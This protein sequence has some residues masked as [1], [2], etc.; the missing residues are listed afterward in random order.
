MAGGARASRRAHRPA[1]RALADSRDLLH[2]ELR[3]PLHAQAE[4]RSRAPAAVGARHFRAGA[5]R[6]VPHCGAQ[7]SRAGYGGVCRV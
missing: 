7:R 3:A 4:A 5:V 6:T 2:A 1:G